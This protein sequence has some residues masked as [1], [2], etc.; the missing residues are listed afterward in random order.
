MVKSTTSDSQKGHSFL[1]GG[2]FCTLVIVLGSIIM[3]MRDSP[4]LNEY[5]SKTISSTKPYNT[6]EEFYPHYRREHSQ[7]ITRQWHYVGTTLFLIY[8]LTQPVLL[9]PILSGAF[10]A[11]TV[12]P[13]FRHLSNGLGEI[14]LFMTVYIIGG[15]LLTGSFKKT[16]VPLLLGYSFA[17]IGHFYFEHNKPATFIYPTYSLM[18]DFRMMYDAIKQQSF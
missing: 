2:L 9:V 7:T 13:F 1:Y 15:K 6:F 8:L 10:A 3:Q 5:Q 11:Y 18:G 12:M 16:F 14:I 17:W 4:P